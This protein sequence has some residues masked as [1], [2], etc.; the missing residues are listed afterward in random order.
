M[1]LSEIVK[2]AKKLIEDGWTK[3][4]SARDKYGKEVEYFS[5]NACQFCA[6]GAYARIVDENRGPDN[7]YWQITN[8]IRQVFEE[9][10]IHDMQFKWPTDVSATPAFNDSQESVEPVLELYDRVITKL[11]AHEATC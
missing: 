11:E 5:P 9:V 6:V 1:K 2:N 10:L 7:N 3:G 4:T 8:N